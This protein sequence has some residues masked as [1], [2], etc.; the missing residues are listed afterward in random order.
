MYKR[1]EKYLQQRTQDNWGAWWHFFICY[2]WALSWSY[3]FAFC[4]VDQRYAF[5]A[6]IVFATYFVMVVYEKSQFR[7]K[8]F[9]PYSEDVKTKT[10][11]LRDAMED[12]AMNHFGFFAG[13]TGG[14]G[15]F[16]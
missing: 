8:L 13:V 2:I 4:T 11:A 15:L 14:L 1:I 9:S 7:T 6:I 3:V 10:E 12:I 16:Y 5:G